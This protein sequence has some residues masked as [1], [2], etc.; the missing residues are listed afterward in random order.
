MSM[1]LAQGG[2]GF[3][4]FAES[5][6]QYI[7]GKSVDEIEVNFVDVPHHEAHHFL[8]QVASL[9]VYRKE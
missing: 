8:S 7:S 6:Y 9:I 3:P 4:F 5:V 1:S 2:N